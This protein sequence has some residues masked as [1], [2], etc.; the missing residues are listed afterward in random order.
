MHTSMHHTQILLLLF[1]IF[2]PIFSKSLKY[3]LI[4]SECYILAMIDWMLTSSYISQSLKY[5]K[6]QT[7]NSQYVLYVIES[8]WK[9]WAYLVD[10]E[11]VEVTRPVPVNIKKKL[12]LRLVDVVYSGNRNSR[13]LAYLNTH[14]K[15][16]AALSKLESDFAQV[17]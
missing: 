16:S 10:P 11:I 2:F 4:F 15:D 1:F 8:V 17:R 5:S 13:E 7:F 12:I 3:Q 14:R 9:L 6:H